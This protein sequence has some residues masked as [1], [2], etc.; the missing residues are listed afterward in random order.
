MGQSPAPLIV[1]DMAGVTV[2]VVTIDALAR[3]Q[4]VAQRLGRQ[5]CL[6]RASSELQELIDLAGLHDVLPLYDEELGVELERQ[7]EDRE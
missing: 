1:C 2:D 7:S 3:L 6:R 4:L 5:V